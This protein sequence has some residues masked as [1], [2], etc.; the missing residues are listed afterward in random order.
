[1]IG[2]VIQG[3]NSLYMARQEK[4]NL[5]GLQK[6]MARLMEEPYQQYS[7][8]P[9]MSQAYSDISGRLNEYRQLETQG[10]TPE[11]RAT[12]M[13]GAA[14]QGMINRQNAVRAGG[15]QMAR[16]MSA[17]DTNANLNASLRMAIEDARIQES[18]RQITNQLMGQKANVA[19]ALQQQQ[20]LMVRGQQARRQFLEQNLGAAMRDTRNRMYGAMTSFGNAVAGAE[21]EL[22]NAAL[23][24]ATGGAIPMIGDGGGETI[25]LSGDVNKSVGKIGGGAKLFK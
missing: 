5:E 1:M 15:G 16:Y 17:L 9:T 23:T 21:D 11:Q 14:T 20:N 13:Q 12:I 18:R 24:M 10:L 7:L 19:G 4:K 8:D 2:D 25:D 22:Q 3:I 6:D